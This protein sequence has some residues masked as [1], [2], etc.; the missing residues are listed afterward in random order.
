MS[1]C[2]EYVAGY[3]VIGITYYRCNRYAW[4]SSAFGQYKLPRYCFNL[5]LIDGN[6]EMICKL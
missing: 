3:P 2:V 4:T 5:G 6:T 1:G